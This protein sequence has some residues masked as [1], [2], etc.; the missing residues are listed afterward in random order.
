MESS[1]EF[2]EIQGHKVQD[3]VHSIANN[4]S[5]GYSEQYVKAVMCYTNSIIH[6]QK[7]KW[8]TL[9][10]VYLMAH[11]FS[12]GHKGKDPRVKPVSWNVG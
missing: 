5:Y 11:R 1:F 12:H 9:M 2:A 6:T 10:D 7:D 4:L 8:L 3:S